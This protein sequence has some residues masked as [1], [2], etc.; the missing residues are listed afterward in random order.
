MT[1]QKDDMKGLKDEL[2]ILANCNGPHIVQYVGSWIKSDK[3]YIAMEYCAAGSVMD[4]MGVCRM[5]LTESEV[6]VCMKHSLEGLA[7]LHG[8]KIV[9]RGR[10]GITP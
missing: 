4:L 10:A 5:T 2:M 9:H 6:A 8:Q 1:I 3:F 7:H